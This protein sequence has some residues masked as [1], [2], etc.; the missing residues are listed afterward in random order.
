MPPALIKRSSL[1]N[2]IYED[3]RDRIISGRIVPGARLTVIQ[4]ANDYDTSQAPVREALTRLGQDGLVVVEPY[5][6]FKVVTLSPG[7]IEDILKLRI[8]TDN[9]ALSRAIKRI[10][11]DEITQL[12]AFIQA[13]TEA[14][15]RADRVNL[16]ENDVAF[17]SR[18]CDIAD[19]HFLSVTWSTIVTQARLA[20]ATA[21][22]SV[23]TASLV[24]IAA[25]HADILDAIARRDTKE[26]KRL[27]EDHLK[28]AFTNVLPT[29]S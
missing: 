3:L 1:S 10:T 21:N 15:E 2:S 16:T 20:T 5:R 26:A 17:H 28:Y 22:R 29:L 7:D 25:M 9:V 14:A 24:Q 27:N 19:S 6:G 18:I 4:I 13:M 8:A 23:D 12:G 11:D